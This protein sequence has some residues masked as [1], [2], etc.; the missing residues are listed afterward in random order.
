MT[1]LIRTSLVSRRYGVSRRTVVR[2]VEAGILPTPV[3]INRRM[4]FDEDELEEFE[5]Q[6]KG[7]D[8]SEVLAT[9]VR[10]PV[11]LDIKRV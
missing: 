8:N 5:R 1:A 2:W 3:M 10:L 11:R 6:R 9:P 7:C 4:Y